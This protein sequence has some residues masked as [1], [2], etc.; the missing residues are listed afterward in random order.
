M[1]NAREQLLK[2]FATASVVAQELTA[3]TECVLPLQNKTY[4]QVLSVQAIQH[5]GVVYVCQYPSK[6][7]RTSSVLRLRSARTVFVSKRKEISV[8]LLNAE[9]DLGALMTNVFKMIP[10]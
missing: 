1:A 2:L 4:V 3:R 9:M 6:L 7:A 10:V 5:V 8:C